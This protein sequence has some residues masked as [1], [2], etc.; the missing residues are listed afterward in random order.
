MAKLKIQTAT[1]SSTQRDAY[2]SPI[3]INGTNI[4]GTG[5][6]T[7]LSVPTIRIQYLRD[8]G[9]AVENGFIIFQKGARKFEVNNTSNANV[10]V[11]SLVNRSNAA[12]EITSANTGAIRVNVAVITGANLS[13]IGTGG[14]G[15]TNARTFAYLTFTAANVAGYATPVVGYQLTGNSGFLTS[16]ISGNVQV[17]AINS[18]TNVTISCPDQSITTNVTGR[19]QVTETFNAKRI[20]NKYVWDWSDRKWR[21]YLGTPYTDGSSTL[22]SQPTWQGVNLVRVDNA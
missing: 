17:V 9:G 11:V 16:N 4:G 19:I 5:G 15:Y 6:D 20:S 8:S 21:F 2:V 13:N 22:S 10:T 18:A 7:A 3:Q 12:A 14:G 1:G